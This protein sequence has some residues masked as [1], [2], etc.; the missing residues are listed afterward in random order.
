MFTDKQIEELIDLLISLD[1][2][3]KLYFGCDSLAYPKVMKN[4][5]GQVVFDEKGRTKKEWWA[6]YATVLI[7]HMNGNNGCRI[8]RNISYE[9]TYD[10]KKDRP[11]M[12]LMGEV[13]RVVELFNQLQPIIK[14]FDVEI[15]LDIS[16]D[17]K[18]GSNCVAK[19][20][21]GYVLGVTQIEPKLK[22]DAWASSFGADGIGRGFD[23]RT[24]VNYGD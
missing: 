20:A 10:K 4:K 17:P 16:T 19:Q 8:F 11:A 6:K 1:E 2:D 24:S 14:D 9:R 22:P 21:A 7:V 18:N 12:R 5:D 15:H 3:T 13:Y 23:K